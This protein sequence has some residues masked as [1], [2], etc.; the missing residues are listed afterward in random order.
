MDELPFVREKYSVEGQVVCSMVDCLSR[1]GV[2][3]NL[4]HVGALVADSREEQIRC[5]GSGT[6][7]LSSA[8]GCIVSPK[9]QAQ[10]LFAQVFRP[11][12]HFCV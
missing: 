6:Q 11:Q 1:D 2:S 8:Q 9:S 4:R 3:L 7:P 5:Q 10:N 12:W